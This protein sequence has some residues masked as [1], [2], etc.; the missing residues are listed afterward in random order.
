M[1]LYSIWSTAERLEVGMRGSLHEG[2]SLWRY[3]WGTDWTRSS[4]AKFM[5]IKT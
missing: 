5:L 4:Y 3:A 1:R 2:L